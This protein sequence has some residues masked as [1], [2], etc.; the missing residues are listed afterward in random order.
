MAHGRY[1][2]RT[3]R[4]AAELAFLHGTLDPSFRLQWCLYSLNI[5]RQ[6]ISSRRYSIGNYGV[7]FGLSVEQDMALADIECRMREIFDRVLSR[8][9]DIMNADPKWEIKEDK[10]CQLMFIHGS[11]TFKIIRTRGM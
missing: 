5:T 9:N 2:A 11:F 1:R 7:M 4:L 3:D 8:Y 10:R 6:S